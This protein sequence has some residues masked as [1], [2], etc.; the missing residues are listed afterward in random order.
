[1][2]NTLNTLG[3]DDVYKLL[4]LMSL[5]VLG[6]SENDLGDLK[7]ISNPSDMDIEVTPAALDFGVISYEDPASIR[8]FTITSVGSDPA[9]VTDIEIQGVEAAS[10]TLLMPF[11][12][13]TLETNESIDIQVAFQPMNSEML[14]AEVVVFSNSSGRVI[15]TSSLGWSRCGSESVDYTRSTEF[16]GAT[17]VGCNMPNEI[18]LSNIGRKIWLFTTLVVWKTHSYRGTSSISPDVVT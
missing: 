15:D 2:Y 5:T 9:T 14:F 17:Y 6:C 16:F 10:F 3:K 7:D 1:M 8:T 13:V 12:E 18:T 4:L 11:E